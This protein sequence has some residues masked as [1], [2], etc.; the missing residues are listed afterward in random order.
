MICGTARRPAHSRLVLTCARCRR[1][2]ATP[3]SRRQPAICTPPIGVDERPPNMPLRSD[4]RW[5]AMSSGV[6]ARLL[7]LPRFPL[8]WVFWDDACR[9]LMVLLDNNEQ[10]LFKHLRVDLESGNIRA[11]RFQ[12]GFYSRDQNVPVDFSSLVVFCLSPSRRIEI[13]DRE[14]EITQGVF[15]LVRRDLCRVWPQLADPEPV[16][17]DESAQ[18]AAG[19]RRAEGHAGAGP[20]HQYRGK[21]AVGQSRDLS[22]LLGVALDTQA[23]EGRTWAR[24]QFGDGHSQS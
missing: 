14:S 20:E 4:A 9:R 24:E 7:R 15:A 5:C 12:V 8:D 21:A 17:P 2:S 1:C 18:A 10:A 23:G 22:G 16:A 13:T 3:T 19:H 6:P 11:V